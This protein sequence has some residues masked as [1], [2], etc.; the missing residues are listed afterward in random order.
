MMDAQELADSDDEYSGPGL[1]ND[2]PDVYHGIY[3]AG[4]K[5]MSSIERDLRHRYQQQQLYLIRGVRLAGLKQ[6]DCR[7][8]ALALS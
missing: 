7:A 3:M 4:V 6:P 2:P 8:E 1:A 5:P